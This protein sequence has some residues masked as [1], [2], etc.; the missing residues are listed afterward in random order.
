MPSAE[1]TAVDKAALHVTGEIR[2]RIRAITGDMR[3]SGV[4]R[5]GAKVGAFYRMYGG[6]ANPQAW[7]KGSGAL[8]LIEFDTP[9]HVILPK[10][11]RRSAKGRRLRGKRALKFGGGFYSR[12][13]HPG[14]RGQHPFRDGVEAG[15]KQ[16]GEVF[17][18]VFAQEIRKAWK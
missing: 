18:K 3:L 4:G 11:G 2:D 15:A 6:N 14:T 1:R 8:P 7:I 16:S 13:I 10:G 12:A 9:P 5:S 17:Q